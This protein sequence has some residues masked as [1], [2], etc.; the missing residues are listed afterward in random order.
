MKKPI[1]NNMKMEIQNTVM[2]T[3]LRIDFIF[4]FFSKAWYLATNFIALPENPETP[5]AAIEVIEIIK[6]QIPSKSNPRFLSM[7]L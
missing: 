5:I 7:I 6:D 3:V 2:R 1:I 4:S